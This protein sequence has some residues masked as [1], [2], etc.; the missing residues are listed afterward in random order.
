[1]NTDN[2]PVHA[3]LSR[4]R[5]DSAGTYRTWFLWEERLKKFRSIRRGI[6]AVVAEIE[7]GTFGS[8]PPLPRSCSTARRRPATRT[9]HC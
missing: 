3:L 9:R 8:P 2:D 6:A 1:L 5:D 4:W 7:A